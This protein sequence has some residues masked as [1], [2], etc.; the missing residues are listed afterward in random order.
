MARLLKTPRGASIA[1]TINALLVAMAVFVFDAP[2]WIL[3]LIMLVGLT[4]YAELSSW[5]DRHPGHHDLPN[6]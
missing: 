3:V 4:A 1:G 5:A 6:S 2:A